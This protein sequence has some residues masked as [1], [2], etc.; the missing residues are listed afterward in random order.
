MARRTRGTATLEPVQALAASANG[1]RPRRP[2]RPAQTTRE[3]IQRQARVVTPSLK[4]TNQG[5]AAAAFVLDPS[6]NATSG[7]PTPNAV[8]RTW[9]HAA[10]GY[11]H[12]VP[13]LNAAKMY[14]GNCLSRIHLTVGKRSPDGHVEQG[15]D[16]DEPVEDLDSEVATEAAE[17]ISKLRAPIGGQSELLRS[18][19]EK[20]FIAGE[21]YL[22]PDDTPAGLE[23]ECLSTQELIPEGDHFERYYGPGWS[24]KPLAPETRPI[25]VWRPDS[26]WGRLADSSVRSALEILEEL[27][28]L[29]RLVRASAISRMALA[30]VFLIP[31]ELDTPDDDEDA[32]GSQAE[33]KNPLAVDILN[34]GAKAIDDPASAAAFMPYML[35]GPS[36][37]LKEVRHIP[38][39][40]SGQEQVLQRTEALQRLAQGL[41][42]PVEVI[43]GH[44]ATTFA[45]A[46]QVS[47][48]TFQLHI[49]PTIQLFCDAL[50]VSYLWPAMAANRG[51]DAEHL[52]DAPYPDEILTVAV[53]YDARALISRPDRAKEII[54]TFLHD[55]TQMAVKISEVREALGLDPNDEVP[56]DELAK[57]IDAIRL[58]KIREVIPAPPSDAAVPI[59]D[60]GKAVVPGASGGSK[61]AGHGAEAANS[62][63]QAKAAAEEVKNQELLASGIPSRFVLRVAGAADLT[64]E[65]AVER[66]GSRVKAKGPKAL[67]Q[68]ERDQIAGVPNADVPRVLGLQ[69]V[70]RVLGSDDPAQADVAA[71]ARRVGAWAIEDG[72][73]DAEAV[74]NAATSIVR[75]AVIEKMYRDVPTPI[76]PDGCA[77]ALGGA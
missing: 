61:I 8:T 16:G 58:G 11:V 5:L 53:T 41:D 29:T 70:R 42:L 36:E 14:V 39:Q 30:G 19:G 28:V 22:I 27:V 20:V 73:A 21:L 65:R 49:E 12:S 37:F 50:T 52:A 48:D 54:D 2:R 44:Q 6:M 3:K 9:Q 43:L 32:D 72:R 25:R 31:D 40:A 10:W 24:P 35:Q 75:D 1:N 51:I 18:F 17:L 64:V 74:V 56:D 69:V 23:F 63:A 26:Q 34:T 38:F 59:E 4:V 66:I 68:E 7:Y 45:N 15:F 77:V 13:E 46:A 57:R 62:A 71:F 47:Q 33:A 55:P 60:A 76:T 67:S